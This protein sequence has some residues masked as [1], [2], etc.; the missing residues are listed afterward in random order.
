MKL[1]FLQC[2]TSIGNNSSFLELEFEV[3][4][5]HGVFGYRRSNGV[6]AVFNT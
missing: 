1:L 5:Q 3:C 4:M 2:N 6:M